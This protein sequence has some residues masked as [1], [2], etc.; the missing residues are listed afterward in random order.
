MSSSEPRGYPLLVAGHIVSTFGTSIYVISLVVY[1]AELTDSAVILGAVQFAAYLPAAILGPFAGA[2]VDRWSRKRIIIWADLGR[3]AVMIAAAASALI[4]GSMSLAVV[5]AATILVGAAGVLFVPAVHSI[6]PELVPPVKIKPANGLRTALT[7]A[8][9]LAGNALGG[10][11]YLLLGAPLLFALNGVSFLLSGISEIAIRPISHPPM[12]RGRKKP[13]L[14][15]SIAAGLGLLRRRR[16]IRSTVA[17]Q[18]VVNLLLPPV[19]VSLPFVISEHWAISEVYFGLYFASV[20]AGSI[21]A[22]ALLSAASTTESVEARAFRMGLP[23]VAIVLLLLGVTTLPAV[24]QL[25]IVRWLLFPLFA[26]AGAAV[27]TIHL[28]GV[29]RIQQHVAAEE[30]GRVFAAAETA[31]AAL[32][33]AAY[34]VS[35]GLAELL[36]GTPIVLYAGV[37]TLALAAAALTSRQG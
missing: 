37:G 19:V 15:R 24:A 23:A 5:F 20:L 28:V 29:T 33:P 9:N 22:F 21:I 27:G 8:A 30:R 14:F 6:V 34:A 31:T 1:L 13:P 16:V 4:W 12:P 7:Q 32:L 26:T 35:G 18:V 2:L 25:A 3:G 36:R 11:L 17:T 10:A